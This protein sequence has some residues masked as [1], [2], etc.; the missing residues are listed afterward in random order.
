MIERFDRHGDARVHQEDFNQ[1]LGASGNEKYQE[2]GGAVSLA[3]IADTVTRHAP[4]EDLKRL[5]RLTTFAV[6]IGNLD[7]HAKNLGLLH[8]AIGPVRLAPAYD[9]VPQAHMPNDGR[10][11]LAVNREYR[12]SEITRKD[13]AAEFS[14]WGLPRAA[15]VTAACLD[16]L[17]V[18]VQEETP[19]SGS[20]PE[21]QQQVLECTESLL[22]G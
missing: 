18:V 12:H 22:A 11:A 3:R 20:F 7:M 4:E 6:A 5:A 19:L 15:A 14:T 16:E 13:L 9:V 2:I 17:Q 10:L 21:L 8:P 1:A